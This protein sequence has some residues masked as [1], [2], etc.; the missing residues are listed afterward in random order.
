VKARVLSPALEEIAEAA[1][2]FDSQRAGLGDEFWQSVNATLLRI[3][4]N[5]L[6]FGKSEFATEEVEFRFAVV[7]RFHYVI[8]FLV[9]PDEVQIVAVAHGARRPGYWLRRS[10]K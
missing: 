3:E 9:E 8:H 7:R 4:Q 1:L 10:K 6:G 5:P 2:W